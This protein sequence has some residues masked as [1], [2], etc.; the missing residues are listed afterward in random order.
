MWEQRAWLPWGRLAAI[1]K[2]MEALLENITS[3]DNARVKQACKIAASAGER[4]ETG[5]FFAEGV[6]LCLDL[7][8]SFA[9]AQVFFT[10]K[11]LDGH[12]EVAALAPE[13]FLVAPHVAEKLA[14]TKSTQGLF[15]L[16]RR[17]QRA[18][19]DLALAK[20]VLL[21]ENVAD[22][23]NIGALLRSAAGL[24]LGGAVLAGACADPF[25]PRALRAGMGSV[26]RLAVA[27]FA[28]APAAA[29]FLKARGVTLYAAALEGAKPLP[30]LAPKRPFCLMLGNEGRGLSEAA[31]AAADERVFIPMQNGVESLN[32]AAA[33]AVLM[34]QFSCWLVV[35]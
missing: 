20:G 23:A 5:L 27:S 31:L 9:A 8:Q 11:V 18:P 1:G 13:A 25:S 3:R 19:E 33:A 24:G 22:A 17:P 10:Q 34:Y 35:N 32:V 16:F 28:D 26:G 6:R 30:G 2:R 14:G 15:A 4:A 7:A 12:P 29:A 21:C